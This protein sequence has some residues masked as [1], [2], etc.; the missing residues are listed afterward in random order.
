M[1]CSKQH[2]ITFK[3]LAAAL[4]NLICFINI[5]M[6]LATIPVFVHH[7][8]GY[9]S[10]IAGISVSSAYFST[11]I[12]R[13]MAG[14]WIDT[15][16]PKSSVIIGLVISASGGLCTL[17]ASFFTHMPF[18]ALGIILISRFCMGASESYAST[19]VN[20]WNIG[21]VGV[22]NATHVISWNGVTSYG[23]MA[24]GVPLGYYL[25]NHHNALVGGLAGFSIL[26][27]VMAGLSSILASTYPAIAPVHTNQRLSFTKVFGLVF[28]YGSCLGLATVGFGSIQT[29][30]ALYFISQHWSGSAIALTIFGISF[31]I[32][33]F[34][35][36]NSIEKLGGYIVSIFSLITETVGLIC[37]ASQSSVAGA[38][39]GS[40]LAGCGFSLIYP[41][42]GVIAISKV[43]AENRGSALAAFSLFLDIALAITGPLLGIVQYHLGYHYLFIT[44]ALSTLTGCILTYILY[45]Q[46]KLHP[47]DSLSS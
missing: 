7:S 42:L 16:G 1:P 20:L 28:S 46:N 30:I 39:I 24:I 38:Y 8:L 19:G 33:R 27:F 43:S 45:I 32:I 35:F 3:I 14:K 31:V 29:F 4:F 34:I 37:L 12:T 47:S 18:L 40:A 5:G 22:K 25:A 23:G 9:N 2:A 10:I 15:R 36:K 41:A 17:I 11:L 13:P 44:A 6:P 21:R 26:T